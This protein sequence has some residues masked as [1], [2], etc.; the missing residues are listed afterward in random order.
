M[1]TQKVDHIS[2]RCSWVVR[3][4]KM[5]IK[6]TATQKISAAMLAIVLGVCASSNP[7][8]ADSCQDMT[9]FASILR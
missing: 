6:M 7:L 2:R 1:T 5:T 4:R 8:G 9:S 3:L